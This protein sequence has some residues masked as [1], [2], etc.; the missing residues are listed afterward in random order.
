MVFSR[1]LAANLA[2]PAPAPEA[3]LLRLVS[4]L[5]LEELVRARAGLF[6]APV[7]SHSLSGGEAQRLA[8]GR[9]LLRPADVFIF[10]ESFSQLDK[11]IAGALLDDIL[12]LP[13]KTCLVITHDL[14]LLPRLEKIF[15]LENGHVRLL[16]AVRSPSDFLP[17]CKERPNEKDQTLGF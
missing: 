8:L 16:P 10:D 17:C 13:D 3:E 4:T 11:A 6:G 14:T 15:L 12:S 2:Y 9:T 7:H 1:P 5:S